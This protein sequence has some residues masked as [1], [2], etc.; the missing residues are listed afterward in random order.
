MKAL[1]IPALF[2][3]KKM[4]R[5]IKPTIGYALLRHFLPEVISSSIDSAAL[6][7]KGRRGRVGVAVC[8]QVQAEN[9]N[10]LRG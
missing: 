4:G 10:S 3:L 2:A 5:R 7:L 6:S 9:K 1:R 8:V